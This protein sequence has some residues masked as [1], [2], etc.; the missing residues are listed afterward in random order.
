MESSAFPFR[1]AAALIVIVCAAP[2]GV[3]AQ[4]QEQRQLD[5]VRDQMQALE[6]RL[7]RE[8]ARREREYAA[9][10]SVELESATAAARLGELRTELR[11]QRARGAEL[12]AE[13]A[14]ARERLGAERTAL[15]SQVR[16]SYLTG[17]QEAIK[18]L[19]NQE[20][21]AQ[22]GR[23]IV[24]YDYLNRARGRRI[25]NVARELGHLAELANESLRVTQE[26][27]SLEEA[28]QRELAGLEALRQ[29]RAVEV[30]SLDAAVE[31]SEEAIGRLR[32]EEQRLSELVTE[33]EAL[34]ATF[35]VDSQEP[36]ARTRGTLTWPIA[37]SALNDFGA[38]RAGGQLI[39][40]GIQLAAPGGTAVRAIYHGRVVY[41]DWLPGLGLLVIV[42][43]GD[44]YMSLYGH[45]EALL[46]ES[47]DWVIPGEVIAQV[48]D[49]G[50]QAQTALYFEIRRNGDPV[51][52][53]VWMARAAGAAS[54]AG[55]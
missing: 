55:P 32:S 51:D 18:L 50:G 54:A 39:W 30:A 23:M 28:Q 19:L 35:P 37:G 12:D 46:R 15:A 47:G 9:L 1:V 8:H 16:A 14:R 5:A 44:G 41:S 13:S 42:D 21:P 26:L 33:L 29:D 10:R 45:N 49:S 7:T 2:L 25:A 22:L 20:S 6:T 24:Y 52:P 11:R 36:F 53:R 17:R 4:N 31:S 48:G 34:L 40:N 43:H 38:A 3:L 27:Q